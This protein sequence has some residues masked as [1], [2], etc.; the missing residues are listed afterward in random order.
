MHWPSQWLKIMCPLIALGIIFCGNAAVDAT[1]LF[2][3][4][5]IT[6]V[7]QSE[8][9][10]EVR[11]D[12]V[13]NLAGVKL[14]LEYD[15]DIL[16]FKQALK[17]ELT[18]PMMHVVNDHNPGRLI[19][20]MAAAVGIKGEN[21]PLISLTFQVRTGVENVKSAEIRITESQL[22]SDKLKDLSHAVTVMPITIGQ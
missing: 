19:I 1:E 20:V 18:G 21:F 3:P 5:I 17:S 12:R 4:G 22:M 15:K 9:T 8:I 10:A 16:E 11:I 2:I 13:D 7:G 6:A 14:V